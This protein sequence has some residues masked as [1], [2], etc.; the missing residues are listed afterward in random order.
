VEGALLGQAIRLADRRIEIDREGVGPGSRTGRESS[1]EELAGNPIE[2]ADMAPA[3]A[4]QEQKGT[5]LRVPR[6][7]SAR[8]IGGSGVIIGFACVVRDGSTP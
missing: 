4:P 6:A 7:E 2:L 3:E 1:G 8:V 5:C